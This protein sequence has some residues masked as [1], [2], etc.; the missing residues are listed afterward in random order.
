[1]ACRMYRPSKDEIEVATGLVGSCPDREPRRP[2]RG[3]PAMEVCPAHRTQPPSRGPLRGSPEDSGESY[4]VETPRAV[5][6]S[7]AC[8]ER[9]VV[10]TEYDH[11]GRP[12]RGRNVIRDRAGPP[13]AGADSPPRTRTG[14]DRV[15]HLHAREFPQIEGLSR[16]GPV[17]PIGDRQEG[18]VRKGGGV[19][20]ETD[21]RHGVVRARSTPP[22]CV[23][24]PDDGPIFPGG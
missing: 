5:N 1:M 22:G 12:A 3:P 10:V 19:I 23:P 7:A 24:V 15:D 20:P 6:V 21:V 16:R 8:A 18:W 13:P 4:G 9:H 17:H 14:L 2:R 11:G